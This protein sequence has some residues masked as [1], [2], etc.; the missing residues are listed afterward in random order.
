MLIKDTCIPGSSHQRSFSYS[1]AVVH[2]YKLGSIV[3][4]HPK[5]CGN[6]ILPTAHPH[7]SSQSSV[8]VQDNHKCYCYVRSPSLTC[9]LL[10]LFRVKLE[11]ILYHRPDL[12]DHQFCEFVSYPL[13]VVLSE[14]LVQFAQFN[15][16]VCPRRRSCHVTGGVET[17]ILLHQ[18]KLLL[19]IGS[20]LAA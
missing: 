9:G 14:D 4:R 1:T 7:Y 18:G 3:T 13:K 5:L 6:M 15:T 20:N 16:N 12:H 11:V 10:L 17:S 8:L 2:Q 19:I